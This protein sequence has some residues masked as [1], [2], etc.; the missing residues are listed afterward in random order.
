[1]TI[2]R[3]TS[4]ILLISTLTAFLPSYGASVFDYL[5]SNDASQTPS[6]TK[7][8]VNFY[9]TQ[10]AK[11][12]RTSL[13]NQY[14]IA[15]QRFKQS[16]VKSAY[17]DFN[18]LIKSVVPN[19]FAYSKIAGEMAQIGFFNL[20]QS[21]MD[22]ITEKEV[23]TAQSEDIKLFYFP[24]NPLTKQD[25]I[26]LGEMYSNIIYNAQS[27]E[28]TAELLKNKTLLDRS[29]YANY[30]V[31]L[32]AL[33][34]GDPDT[35]EKYIE[36]AL[37]SNPQ[38]INYQKLK[39]EILL[40]GKK[41]KES[42]K[43]I[44]S[45]RGENLC[46]KE[47]E[48]KVAE[49]EQYTLYKTEKNEVM[50]KYHLGYYYYLTGD[51]SKSIRTLQ[52]AITTKKKTN[53]Q[54]YAL[55]AQVYYAQKE[56]EKAENFALKV[57]NLGGSVEANL[58]LGKLSYKNEDFKSAQKYFKNAIDGE[59]IEPMVWLAMTYS[60]LGQKKQALAIYTKILKNRDDCPQAYFNVAM[61]DAERRT[62]YL[63]KAVMI[64]I[65]YVDAWLE[66]AGDCIGKNKFSLANKYLGIVKY[67]DEN[68]FR[69][70]YYQGLV[71]KAS[72]NQQD[73]NYYFKQSLILNPNFELAKKELGIRI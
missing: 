35:A 44:S 14:D 68:N 71:Y 73:A 40:Q 23:A 12:T 34:S 45:I 2:K 55:M 72:G 53:K 43:V 42:L 26:Y 6:M 52:G 46:T 64:D 10:K 9:P 39:I 59:N 63:K 38:N 47:Y 19:D 15:M 58:V 32:G 60:Q 48:N 49:L 7:E 25:E 18:V 16:N 27:K 17:A 11:L 33:K 70:Y 56:Y 50:K 65:A 4:G 66:L 8:S 51:L 29:D 57:E 1:M 30:I 22:K 67:I 36:I 54:V 20:S 62:E 69:Y 13:L 24:K 28:A 61:N 31:A 21:A 41:P 37:K 5:P 3:I